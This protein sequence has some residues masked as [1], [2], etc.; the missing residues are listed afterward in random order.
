MPLLKPKT[1]PLK[2]LSLV[3]G[4]N[5]QDRQSFI[6]KDILVGMMNREERVIVAR[7]QLLDTQDPKRAA[8]LKQELVFLTR[9]RRY[10][11]G[12]SV[13]AREVDDQLEVVRDISDK[14]GA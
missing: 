3:L 11:W 4:S 12:E 14:R 1:K 2:Q 13:D 7:K 5:N 8:A 6:K 9:G 10:S